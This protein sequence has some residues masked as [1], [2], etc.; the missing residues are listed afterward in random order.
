MGSDSAPDLDTNSDNIPVYTTP[1]GANRISGDKDCCQYS[2]TYT[3]K[4]K[5]KTLKNRDNQE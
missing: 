2:L 3:K 5:H 1:R 4:L